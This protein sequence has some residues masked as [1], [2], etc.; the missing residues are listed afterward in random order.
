MIVVI[1]DGESH[2]DDPVGAARRAAE[3][4]IV[5]HA[6]GI[7]SPQEHP[8]PQERRQDFLK[9]RDGNVV[10]TRLDEETLSKVCN[11]RWWKVC[12]GYKYTK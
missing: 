5:I 2:E 4:G 1:S 6:I 11:N 9:D 8:Y 3:K 10:V 12:K 7:G